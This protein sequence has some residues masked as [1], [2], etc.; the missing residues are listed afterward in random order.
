MTRSRVCAVAVLLG[1]LA[2]ATLMLGVGHA[3]A[4]TKARI[5]PRAGTNAWI[6]PLAGSGRV[7]HGFAP[8]AHPWLAGHRG[9]DLAGRA[10]EA[11]RAAGAGVVSF[12]GSVAGVGVVAVRHDGGLETTYEPVRA[13][14]RAGL[15]VR[16]GQLLGRLVTAG[17]HCRPATCLHWGLRR[18]GPAGPVVYLDPLGLV[19]AARVRLLPLGPAPPQWTGPLTGGA[20]AGAVLTWA[21]IGGAAARRR[22]RPPPAGVASLAAARARRQSDR[23]HRERHE[24][25]P[26]A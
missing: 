24:Q 10:G 20:A 22:N 8:P 26:G 21:A 1:C 15:Q 14:V 16:A 13:V 5:Q 19:G 17:G 9:V 3:L 11:V 7:V 6:E 12:A 25:E 18:G 23:Q 2:A 4:G